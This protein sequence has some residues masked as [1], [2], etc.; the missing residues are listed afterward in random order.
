MAL[1]TAKI[2][3]TNKGNIGVYFDLGFG[4]ASNTFDPNLGFPRPPYLGDI[5]D[6]GGNPKDVRG[7]Y[8]NV[9]ETKQYTVTFYDD[10]LIGKYTSAYFLVVVWDYIGHI[11]YA[12]KF[13]SFTVTAPAPTP[14]PAPAPT[15]V[16][17][18][19]IQIS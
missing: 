11:I 10:N 1:R 16:F 2:T 4:L 13:A 7:Q 12:Y 17:E 15:P 3:V 9:G 6:F 14:A 8:L 19:T 18:I 5:G